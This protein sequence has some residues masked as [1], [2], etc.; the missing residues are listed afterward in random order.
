MEQT[1][2]IGTRRIDFWRGGVYG[3]GMSKIKEVLWI[4]GSGVL[5]LLGLL[6]MY[7]TFLI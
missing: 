1:P 5:I 7:W 3:G 6:V 4:V 2:R